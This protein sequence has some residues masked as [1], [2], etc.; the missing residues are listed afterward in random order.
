MVAE[1]LAPKF[2]SIALISTKSKVA[3]I[4]SKRSGGRRVVRREIILGDLSLRIR[5]VLEIVALAISSNRWTQGSTPSKSPSNHPSDW[6]RLNTILC[7]I[8]LRMIGH[9]NTTSGQEVVLVSFYLGRS[10]MKK[11]MKKLAIWVLGFWSRKLCAKQLS[12]FL[13]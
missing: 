5:L 4:N 7:P 3:R 6:G 2:T 8:K 12:N 11:V 13:Y 9:K 1:R 10:K